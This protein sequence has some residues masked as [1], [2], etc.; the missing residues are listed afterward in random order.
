MLTLE[1][2]VKSRCRLTLKR[3]EACKVAHLRYGRRKAC[4]D[5]TCVV[6][7]SSS[8]TSDHPPS[9]AAL[10]VRGVARILSCAVSAERP[11]WFRDNARPAVEVEGYELCSAVPQY[12]LDL[13][14]LSSCSC[15]RAET[16]A[17]I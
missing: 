15:C 16:H 2:S 7:R 13:D 6:S 8:S 10:I 5:S 11:H 1:R 17:V 4:R 3:C 14:F 12:S 9:E